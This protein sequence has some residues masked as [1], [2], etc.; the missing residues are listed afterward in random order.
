MLLHRII[1]CNAKL[2]NQTRCVWFNT[3]RPLEAVTY[4]K[5]SLGLFVVILLWH[6]ETHF[7]CNKM[8]TARGLFCFD[9]S[10]GAKPLGSHGC[11]EGNCSGISTNQK[12][13]SLMHFLIGENCLTFSFSNLFKFLSQFFHEKK[14]S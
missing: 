1:R 14:S 4:L 2:I 11:R 7:P 12:F 8:K 5:G 9:F 6:V 10:P 3:S 13:S